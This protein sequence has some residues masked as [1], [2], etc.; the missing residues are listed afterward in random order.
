MKL[1]YKSTKYSEKIE[2]MNEL[3][4]AQLTD[5]IKQSF[6]QTILNPNTDVHIKPAC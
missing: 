1:T 4:K 6:N 5:S 3:M 2:Q